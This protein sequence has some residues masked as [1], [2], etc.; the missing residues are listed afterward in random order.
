MCPYPCHVSVQLSEQRHGLR[1]YNLLMVKAYLR[2]K[3]SGVGR[4]FTSKVS[5]SNTLPIQISL[6][7]VETSGVTTS[8]GLWF[9]S[10]SLLGGRHKEGSSRGTGHDPT[11]LK[12][13]KGE[14]RIAADVVYISEFKSL[15]L[16]QSG[17]KSCN[18]KDFGGFKSWNLAMW[19]T[20]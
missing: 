18:L 11:S 15:R 4:N 20:A 9:R 17:L 6:T 8:A 19:C 12:N 5:K 2:R 14:G 7:L 13:R 10:L 16:H 1:C 3:G